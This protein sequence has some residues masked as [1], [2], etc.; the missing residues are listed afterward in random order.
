MWWHKEVPTPHA[1]D[2]K[3]TRQHYQKALR[4]GWKN[5]AYLVI[6]DPVARRFEDGGF[7]K[8]EK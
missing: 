6:S 3:G 5:H 4:D 7:Y 1:Y 8:E 2:Y